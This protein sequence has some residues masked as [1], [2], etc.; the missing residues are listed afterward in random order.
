MR[1][2]QKPLP[3]TQP[4]KATLPSSSI[5]HRRTK[6]IHIL[7]TT[8]NKT[9]YWSPYIFKSIGHIGRPHVINSII[10][11]TVAI[12]KYTAG[13]INTRHSCSYFIF[14]MTT[15][16]LKNHNS[17]HNFSTMRY[18]CLEPRMTPYL[19][20]SESVNT[21]TKLILHFRN[22]K[23]KMAAKKLNIIKWF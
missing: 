22:V 4:R 7:H 6:A 12:F 20:G 11:K 18:P 19:K 8:L 13:K 16:E 10:K 3:T 23:S 5:L 9:Y 21:I 17:I 14:K 1:Y 2:G 15:H